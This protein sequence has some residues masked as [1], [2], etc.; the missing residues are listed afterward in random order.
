M[1]SEADVIII[2]KILDYS[3]CMVFPTLNLRNNVL[4]GFLS[5]TFLV[6]PEYIPD[7]TT[8]CSFRKRIIDNCKEEIWRQLQSQLY[9]LGFENKE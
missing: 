2:S 7:S 4:I 9:R 1:I 8:V 6:F 5:G 3:N